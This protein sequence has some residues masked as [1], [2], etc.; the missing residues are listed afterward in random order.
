[1]FGFQYEKEVNN[2]S[3]NHLTINTCF[4][5]IFYYSFY[6]MMHC[7]FKYFF[8]RSRNIKS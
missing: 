1:M 5:R 7:S 2:K 3:K 4:F 8:R 6:E